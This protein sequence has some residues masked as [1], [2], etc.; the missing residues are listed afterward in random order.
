MTLPPKTEDWTVLMSRAEDIVASLEELE[1]MDEGEL[2]EAELHMQQAIEA[3]MS[4][5]PVNPT[6]HEEMFGTGHARP[7]A[8]KV[9]SVLD[10]SAQYESNVK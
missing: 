8:S 6:V 3:S 4:G 10:I 5:E 9:R 1:D 7:A 2:D